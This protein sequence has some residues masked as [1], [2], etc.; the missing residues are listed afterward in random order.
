[1]RFFLIIGPSSFSLFAIA[2]ALNP[3]ICATVCFKTILWT[4]LLESR[5]LMQNSIFTWW[6]L[7]CEH[8]A[9]DDHVE[10]QG[11][12]GHVEAAEKVAKGAAQKDAETKDE[13]HFRFFVLLS[14]SLEF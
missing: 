2:R 12:V 1:M 10:G 4:A 7:Y 5:L 13:K 9:H 14:S 6:R 8:A 11:E 3:L